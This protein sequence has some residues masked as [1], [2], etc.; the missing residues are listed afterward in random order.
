MIVGGTLLLFL[1]SGKVAHSIRSG[2]SCT[3]R[4]LSDKDGWPR[5]VF[6]PSL[7]KHFAVKIEI[8]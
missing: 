4:V 1:K 3:E 2:I 6:K 5:G 7:S 8:F